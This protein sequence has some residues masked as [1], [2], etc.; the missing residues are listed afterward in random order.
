[1]V[2][3]VLVVISAYNHSPGNAN[4]QQVFA[5]QPTAI[6]MPGEFDLPQLELS[7]LSPDLQAAAAQ[8]WQQLSAGQNVRPVQPQ[9]AS[10]RLS[11]TV[12]ELRRTSDGLVVLGEVRNIGPNE[13]VVPISAFQLLD[14]A[15]ES[16]VADGGGAAT[17]APG[18]QTPLELSVP[19]PPGRGLLLRTNLPPDP[20]VEQVLLVIDTNSN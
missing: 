18:D 3:I 13:V 6:G 7:N 9:V 1:M 8:L 14:S 10:A 5:A 4:L 2:G 12:T 11:I 15:G 19:L 16:Y 20:V 17:L